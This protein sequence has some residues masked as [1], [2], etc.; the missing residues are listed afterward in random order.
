MPSKKPIQKEL[1]ELR[2]QTKADV[3]AITNA[4]G[5]VKG[6]QSLK[7]ILQRNHTA[8]LQTFGIEELDTMT[9]RMLE[10]FYDDDTSVKDRAYIWARLSERIIGLP[11][12]GNGDKESANSYQGPAIQINIQQAPSA[13]A[14]TQ[15]IQL[16]EV[17]RELG[18]SPPSQGADDA[19]Q[20]D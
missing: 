4:D 2:E 12:S 13:D 11:R 17:E 18:N 14:P 15:F 9:Q 7:H 16:E 5:T 8:F 19:E 20:D 3:Q 6:G 1:R 10:D